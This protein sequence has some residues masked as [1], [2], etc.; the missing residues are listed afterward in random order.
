MQ[1]TNQSPIEGNNNVINNFIG[2][3]PKGVSKTEIIEHLL[4]MNRAIATSLAITTAQCEQLK[5]KIHEL[6]DELK[7]DAELRRSLAATIKDI[8]HQ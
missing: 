3:K 5:T 4:E 6:E 1:I 2:V 8:T 7:E